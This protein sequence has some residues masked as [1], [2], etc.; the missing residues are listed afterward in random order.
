[1]LSFSASNL[2][3]LLLLS[4]YGAT[5]TLAY[6]AAPTAIIDAGVLI[7]K[8]TSLPVA[9][10]PVNQ[11]LG[12]PFAQ[13]PPER[14]SAPQA[15]ARFRKPINATAWK[16]ACIQQ[17]RYP[18]AS[19][20]V[21]QQIFNNP[22][23]VESEDCLYLNVYAPSTP[24]GGA[25]RA[26]LFFIFG[27]SLQFG[28]GGQPMY[29][30]S[31]F[32]AY[33]DVIV[34]TTNYRTNVFG[35]P[36]SPE[37]PPT[38]HNL[39]FLDQRFALDWVQRNIHA[40]GGD[41]SKVTIFG[42]SAGAF[43]ID[44]MLTSYPKDS[45]PPFRAAI[46]QSGQYSYRAAPFTSSVP[47]WYNLTAQLGCPG[48]Y[49]NNLTCVRAAPAT[50]VQN[51]INMNSLIFNPVPDNVTLVTNPAAQ[52]LSG[53]IA[54]IPVLGG[55]NSQEG[56]VFTLGQTN[57]TAFLQA[58]YAGAPA[59]IPIIEAAYPIGSNGLVTGNDVISQIVTDIT[60]QCAQALWANA[61]ASI[62]IPAWRY[63][64]NAS[65]SNTQAFPTLGAFHSSELPLVFRTYDQANVTTQEQ[66]LG[67]F[68]S[69]AWAR[70]AKNPL[71]GPGWN[72]IGSGGEGMVLSGASEQVRGGLLTD[73]T[74][75][76]VPGDWNVG[77]LGDVGR[78]KGSGV[79]VLPQSDLD[80]KCS[81]YRPVYEAIVGS[82]G[83]PPV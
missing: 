38:G 37:L 71:A 78:V 35:F 59:F 50:K 3:H 44:S 76:V 16:P 46:L 8:T 21:T 42:E 81:L 32:A 11:F 34:V 28:N 77:V 31:A 7:G 18:L 26:V 48:T 51:I 40:F 75:G 53:N 1:M 5:T 10:G 4:L 60:F 65:F 6:D 25:G 62:G 79:T 52:R 69:G 57:I 64:F 39:G 70:F 49:R 2:C 45:K 22:R 83:M 27:G 54:H 29:D 56:R 74:A 58:N 17:F 67:Q 30:G 9:L 19:S 63:Y 68:M 61:T 66:A 80:F 41:K 73:Q 20:Q 14:F 47:A 36:S 24:A 82:A 33:E 23:P 55:T 12:V 13:S 15:P 43:S 72:P